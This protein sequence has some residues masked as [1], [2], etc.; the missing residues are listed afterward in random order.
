MSGDVALCTLSGLGA[1]TSGGTDAPPRHIDVDYRE[2]R[3]IAAAL[4]HFAD[5]SATEAA[6]RYVS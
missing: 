5:E 1:D 3:A 2:A 6:V 4:G